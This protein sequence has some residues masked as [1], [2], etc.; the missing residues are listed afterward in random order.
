MA[1]MATEVPLSDAECVRAARDGDS[2]AAGDLIRKHA[3]G[4]LTLLSRVLGDGEVA[5]DLAQETFLRAYR[6]LDRFDASRSFRAWLNAIAWNLA[7]DHLRQRRRR[8]ER[9]GL[10]FEGPRRFREEAVAEEPLDHR[11]EAPQTLLERR[12]EREAVRR[13]LAQLPAAQR[14]ALVLRDLEGFSYEE[15]AR[16]LRCRLGTVKSRISRARL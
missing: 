5:L 10:S 8:G 1:L 16:V 12:E 9:V 7:L 13:A 14:A 3:P 4:V 6:S 15:V 11:E 2:T